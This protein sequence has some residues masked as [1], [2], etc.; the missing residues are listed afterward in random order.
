MYYSSPDRPVAVVDGTLRGKAD[1]DTNFV[2]RSAI[3]IA[4]YQVNMLNG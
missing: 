1:T 3:F 2:R 4:A